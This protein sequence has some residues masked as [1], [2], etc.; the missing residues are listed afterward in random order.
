MK[1]LNI[2]VASILTELACKDLSF[3]ACQCNSEL[4]VAHIT[5]LDKVIEIATDDTSMYVM[6]HHKDGAVVQMNTLVNLEGDSECT[7]GELEMLSHEIYCNLIGES[8]FDLEL[9]IE[10]DPYHLINTIESMMHLQGVL[11]GMIN[12]HFEMEDLTKFTVTGNLH[13]Y[14]ALKHIVAG[15]T[16]SCK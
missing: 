15:I 1:T 5:C 16:T 3:S 6:V 12:V 4:G 11:D 2:I 14:R 13:Y 8:S 7:M 9:D 10:V